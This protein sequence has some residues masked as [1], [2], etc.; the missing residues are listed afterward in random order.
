MMPK[1]PLVWG[2]GFPIF[3]ISAAAVFPAPQTEQQAMAV[4]KGWLLTT[5]APLNTP[6]PHTIGSVQSFR[7]QQ[8][9]PVYYV[10]SLKPEGFIIM[11][12]DDEVEPI[13]AFSAEGRYEASPGN[14]LCGL[15][16]SN[17]RLRADAQRQEVKRTGAKPSPAQAKWDRLIRRA[18]GVTVFSSSPDLQTLD[19][20]R[21]APFIQ[22]RW[23]Q[24]TI[25][26]A[27]SLV[28]CYNYYTPPYESGNSSNYLSGCNST[29]WAQ[30]MRYFLYPTQSIGTNSFSIKVDGVRTNRSLRGGDG[31]GGPYRWDRMPLVPDAASSEEQRQAIGALTADIGVAAGTSYAAAASGAYITSDRLKSVFHFSNAIHDASFTNRFEEKV[32]PNLDA[33]LPILMAIC[34]ESEH[35]VVCDGY[36]YNL[37]TLYHHLNL[38]W[39][40]A[41]DAWYHLP[42]VNT[43]WS[44]YTN[45]A[46][47]VYN[48]YP[49]GSGEII[50]GRV[51]DTNNVPIP[52]ATVKA[53]RLGQ[54]NTTTSDSRGVFAFSKLPSLT[55]IAIS[56]VRTG[57]QF[58]S[59]T[60]TTGFSQNEID[61][62]NKWG[63]NFVGLQ[64]TNVCVI[65][66][67]VTARDGR[68]LAGVVIGFS[69]FGETATSDAE[70]RF[71]HT[72]RRGWSGGF[73]PVK[74]QHYF[75]PATLSVTNLQVNLSGQDFA[76]TYYQ[77]VDRK[78]A[79]QNNGAG[80][81]DAYTDLQTALGRAPVGT[82]LWVA[83]GVYTPGT[84]RTDTFQCR[85]G[86]DL[87]GGFSGGET[88]RGQRDPGVHVT[89]LSGDIGVVGEARDN[90]YHV[91][92]GANQVRMDGFTITGGN[93]NGEGGWEQQYGGGIFNS[94]QGTTNF[95]AVN[96][97]VVGNSAGNAGGG[98]YYGALVDCVVASNTAAYGGGVSYVQLTNCLVS[99]NVATSHGGGSFCATNVSSWLVGNVATN[100]GGGGAY[101]WFMNCMV[102]SNSAVSG[103]GVG[104]G[105][106]RNCLVT[107]NT[108]SWYGGGTYRSTNSNCTVVGNTAMYGGGVY[109]GVGTNCIVYQNVGLL[110]GANW[111][112]GLVEYSCTVPR[113]GG[114]G[115]QTN[116]PCFV[117][118]VGGDYRLAEQSPCINAGTNQEWMVGALDLA[119][120]PR[121]LN[122]VVDLGAYEI[123]PSQN[124][125]LISGVVMLRSG[126]GVAGVEIKFSDEGGTVTTDATGFFFRSVPQGW[127][128]EFT[129]V[130]AQHYFEPA[131]LSVTNLQVNLSGQDFAA[132]YYQCVDR[133]AVGQNNGAGWADA[134]TDLQTALGRA[135][136]GTELWVAAGVYTP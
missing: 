42:E 126:N 33:R 1:K 79:G 9:A 100:C 117:D 68:A 71:F 7:N 55:S 95:V 39:S 18:S 76:A 129:P 46:K 132:T 5:P 41:K 28:A 121:V 135:P 105:V 85:S 87:V 60:V 53:V 83:A 15:V 66:G 22:T 75:E 19:D 49:T 133:K 27:S 113:P 54:T 6:M 86:V 136:V 11:A 101:G 81:A 2:V 23:D 99:G 92:R 67:K 69:G 32:H 13:I 3:L 93:A 16:E 44:D 80:W 65:S 114:E 73:T 94:Y 88:N 77:C 78:A 123:E 51:T 57:F 47:F 70:G 119:G 82:E 24:G 56:V 74:A 40:G 59:R 45:V 37:S 115:N 48:I 62:G 4:A 36:G 38:G 25:S 112:G 34:S 98:V 21:V 31:K 108:G 89:I 110:G 118:V 109:E 35:S 8:S 128:G 50:S 134:Y 104:Y 12:A 20:L 91:V 96:C 124:T 106:L 131:T 90:V 120:Q 64:E 72:I 111:Q 107:G 130:K 58:S 43:G 10:V 97:R 116:Q 14:P 63:I 125:R 61:T 30:I 17:L 29:A 103:G 122:G 26:G 84:N 127:S 52:G 102:V